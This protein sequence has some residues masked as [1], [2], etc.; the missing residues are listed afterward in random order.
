MRTC[1]KGD[2]SCYNVRHDFISLSKFIYIYI[3]FTTKQP[4]CEREKTLNKLNE[5][6]T[7]QS[8]HLKKKQI[9]VHTYRDCT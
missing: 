9:I 5:K 4:Q 6:I 1:D 7:K 8:S 2:L 3:D